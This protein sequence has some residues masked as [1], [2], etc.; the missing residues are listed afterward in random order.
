[1]IQEISIFFFLVSR[2]MF[3]QKRARLLRFKQEAFRRTYEL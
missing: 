1:M 3:Q 2:K